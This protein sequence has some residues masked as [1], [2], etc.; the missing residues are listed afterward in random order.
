MLS[1]MTSCIDIIHDIIHDINQMI[2]ISCNLFNIILLVYDIIHDSIIAIVA[3]LYHSFFMVSYTILCIIS[4]MVSWLYYDIIYYEGDGAEVSLSASIVDRE[5]EAGACEL[6]IWYTK[7][8]SIYAWKL[9]KQSIQVYIMYDII[10]ILMIS[11]S[12]QPMLAA[13]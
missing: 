12:L 9:N 6:W 10:K 4:N 3:I 2:M 11:E 1:C 7:L 13:R 8:Q 5:G